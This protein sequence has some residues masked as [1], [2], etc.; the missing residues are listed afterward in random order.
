MAA[1]L[2]SDLKH[3]P[4]IRM[5]YLKVILPRCCKLCDVSEFALGGV[6]ECETLGLHAVE[7]GRQLGDA[8]VRELADDEVVF[9]LEGNL[10]EI[11]LGELL[12][13]IT[14]KQD[15]FAFNLNIHRSAEVSVVYMFCR[16][17]GKLDIFVLKFC[18]C[19]CKMQ[20]KTVLGEFCAG[21]DCIQNRV[22]GVNNSLRGQINVVIR[23]LPI[24]LRKI[25]EMENAV[26]MVAVTM[27][28]EYRADILVFH[29]RPQNI[30]L[31]PAPI[32]DEIGHYW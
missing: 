27:R 29:A 26:Y 28:G 9:A 24:P 17:I 13:H 8:E 18:F 3:V 6:G 15:S 21:G 7:V 31:K 22:D 14:R 1:E 10:R 20:T 5:K 2:L 25:D 23:V 4:I 32:A 12:R 19:R 16:D 11:V 30:R